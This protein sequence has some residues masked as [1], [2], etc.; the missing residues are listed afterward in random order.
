M[1]R[2]ASIVLLPLLVLL[3]TS[4]AWPAALPAPWSTALVPALTLLLLLACVIT[5][6]PPL[7]LWA[8]GVG[9]LVLLYAYVWNPSHSWSSTAGLVPQDY[10]TGWPAAAYPPGARAAL[11]FAGTVWTAFVAGVS[12]SRRQLSWLP[13][14]AALAT[15]GMALVVISQRL[16]PN[17]PRI[18]EFT[19]IFVNENHYAVF[20]N[21]LLPVVLAGAAR[22]R[23]RAVQAG[24]PSSPA[25]LF[26]LAAALSAAGVVMSKSRAGVAVMALLVGAHV[27]L[28][29]RTVR[30]Y[31][32]AGVPLSP[33]FK[34][35]GVAAFL[36][37]VA[38]AVR[39]FWAEW[40]QVSAITS[41]WT[42]RSG[43]LRHSFTAW[44]E[45]PRWGY[46]PGSFAIIFPYYQAA[47]YARHTIL[48]AHCEPMQFLVEYGWAG[49]AILLAL[50][51]L[52]FST[53]RAPPVADPAEVPAFADCERCAF[54][55]ALVAGVLHCL[56]D[57]PL[58]IPLL[59]LLIALWAG[60]WVAS[61]PH[62]DL[63]PRS[64]A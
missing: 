32:F 10:H 55:L 43:I 57:F 38:F 54:G 15:A 61:R 60:V 20:A 25:G 12:L 23:F 44:Q 28:H 7:R 24:L 40:Q 39:A 29:W 31:P 47:E 2:T 50:T 22:A 9:L 17:A 37:A 26:Y 63:T 1:K 36:T 14:L 13:A 62:P 48:H 27:L 56:V 18:R 33:V 52:A 45:L 51:A 46:G 21:L 4:A 6:P 64:E 58:R 11:L 53:R 49:V 8:A 42:Y 41:E 19:G 34:A 30:R 16:E 59:A 5:Q 35:L 3:L